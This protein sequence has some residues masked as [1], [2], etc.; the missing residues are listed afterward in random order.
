MARLRIG[1]GILIVTTAH[2]L[3]A[4]GRSFRGGNSVEIENPGSSTFGFELGRENILM[5]TR[6]ENL[7]LA[8]I[9]GPRPEAEQRERQNNRTSINGTVMVPTL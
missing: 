7:G 1:T 9:P 4:F 6:G 3:P 2:A 8:L 5:R